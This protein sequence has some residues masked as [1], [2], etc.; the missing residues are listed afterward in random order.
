MVRVVIEP[1]EPALAVAFIFAGEAV[2][3]AF[4]LAD[5]AMDAAGVAAAALDA[6][7]LTPGSATSA[8]D[9]WVLNDSSAAS[10]AAV[11]PM[12]KMARRM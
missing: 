12:V 2:E 10:P 7:G 5:G 11:L 3:L 6:L 1:P 8:A 4:G 9:V